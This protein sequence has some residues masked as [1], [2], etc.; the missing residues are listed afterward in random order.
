MYVLGFIAKKFRELADE[1]RNI[2]TK[3]WIARMSRGKLKRMKPQL[4]PHFKKIEQVF[5]KKHGKGIVPGLNAVSS[6]FIACSK[7][8]MPIPHKIIKF[9]LRCR[10]HFQ[11]KFSNKRLKMNAKSKTHRKLAKIVA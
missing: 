4:I 11:I 1:R 5:R 3:D 2:R 8:S 7:I 9:Y 10:I 6:L